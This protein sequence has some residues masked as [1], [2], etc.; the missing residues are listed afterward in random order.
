MSK[1]SRVQIYMD[2]LMEDYVSSRAKLSDISISSFFY[3]LVIEHIKNNKITS[4]EI[5]II[6]KNNEMYEMEKERRST[7]AR[8]NIVLNSHRKINDFIIKYYMT[9]RGN[10]PYRLI[11]K[12]ISGELK[13]I[14][15][16]LQP[17]EIEGNQELID[18]WVMCLK[19]TAQCEKYCLD[20]IDK[21]V[22]QNDKNFFKHRN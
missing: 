3:R 16:T 2:R 1:K 17:D 22:K 19:S 21:W 10:I 14:L 20:V 15:K 9:V 4:K 8:L 5:E 11:Q 7:M 12:L 13:R 18:V 6:K